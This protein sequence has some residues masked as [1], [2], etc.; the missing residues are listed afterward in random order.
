MAD[1]SLVRMELQQQFAILTLQR[2]KQLNALNFA[3][4]QELESHIET[5][6]SRMDIRVVILRGEGRAFAAGADIGSMTN[7]KPME[8][9]TFARM[10]QNIITK[11]EQLPQPTIALIQ[12]Y[13]L[14]GGLELAMAC[15]IR[16][17]AEGSKFGQPEVT[18]GIIPGFGG[19]QRLPRIIGQGRALQLLLTGEHI[20]A[21]QALE[22]G[23]VTRVV[24]EED[25]S[26]AGM[27][28]A[29]TLCEMGP[30][31]L[32]WLKQAVYNGAELDLSKGLAMEASLFGLCFTTEDQ[33]EG[34]S[35]FI[36]RRKAEFIGK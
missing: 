35:A 27:E 28:M 21:K 17:A 11:L 16:L 22:Y 7:Y 34:M 29:Q 36:N 10:G 3:L 30:R 33:K 24:S 18:L 2:P 8:A 14:G 15:D 25:L 6:Q 9:E 4:L 32:T 19:S 23:L 5:L 26:Q 1:T 13:A 12:G 31:A 20:D